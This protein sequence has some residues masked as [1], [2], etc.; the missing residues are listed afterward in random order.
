VD[1]IEHFYHERWWD[2]SN[3]KWNL[4]GYIC[5]PASLAWGGLGYIAVRWGNVLSLDLLHL[6]PEL[7][8]K[9]LILVLLLFLCVDVFASFMLLTGISRNP[10]QWEETDAQIDKLSARLSSWISERV[11]RRVKKAYPRV[12]KT[13]KRQQKKVMPLHP[14]VDFIRLYY[15]LLLVHF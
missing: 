9:I 8:M 11:E 12:R 3:V 4:D 14:D 15:F 6:L 2:Y 1:L 13:E 7:V 10:K 5:L